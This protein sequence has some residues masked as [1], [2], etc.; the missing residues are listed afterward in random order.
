[1]VFP[2]A[3]G[4]VF[5][6]LSSF[7]CRILP[8]VFCACR[9]PFSLWQLEAWREGLLQQLGRGVLCARRLQLVEQSC[10]FVY[11]CGIWVLLCP[12]TSAA[13]AVT[14]GAVT[15]MPA[16]GGGPPAPL[17]CMVCLA[18]RGSLACLACP[19]GLARLAC[20]VCLACRVCLACLAGRSLR[21]QGAP[22]L[23]G[24]AV[25]RPVVGST[26]ETWLR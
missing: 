16:E 21:C 22:A 17:R 7:F 4:A 11:G 14:V 23:V 20:L 2:F 24:V 25:T 10:F 18:R 19:G 8:G 15:A 1:M 3:G 9:D 12:S 5:A 26:G 13:G 6:A